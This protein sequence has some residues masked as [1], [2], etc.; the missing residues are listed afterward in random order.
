MRT[1]LA[2]SL[3]RRGYCWIAEWSE[4]GEKPETS[5]PADE[6]IDSIA[7]L[8]FANLS[9]DPEQDYFCEGLAE[10]IL[11]AAHAHPRIARYGANLFLSRSA[12]KSKTSGKSARRST[13]GRFWKAAYAT[14]T[15]VFALACNSST[16]EMFITYGRKATTAR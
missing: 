12:E 7:A 11:N 14:R 6:T 16:R 3:A 5:K 10:E 2:I 4:S 13:S 9:G 1:I 15:V 8:P